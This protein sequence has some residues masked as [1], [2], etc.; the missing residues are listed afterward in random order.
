MM[1]GDSSFFCDQGLLLLLANYRNQRQ[2]YRKIDVSRSESI[3]MSF[4][5]VHFEYWVVTA[6]NFQIST[7]NRSETGVFGSC[8]LGANKSV[9]A[10]SVNYI[11]SIWLVSDFLKSRALGPVL[12]GAQCTGF[13]VLHLGQIYV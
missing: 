13:S 12:Y 10:A 2:K 5:G 3:L 6:F 4:L 9:S 1:L 8:T 7:S 11:C